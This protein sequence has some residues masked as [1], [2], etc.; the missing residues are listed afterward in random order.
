MMRVTRASRRT[1]EEGEEAM[2]VAVLVMKVC[3]G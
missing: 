1:A 2:A 3:M